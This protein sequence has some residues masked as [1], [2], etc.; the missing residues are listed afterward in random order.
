MPVVMARQRQHAV[1]AMIE[2]SMAEGLGPPDVEPNTEE[3]V[4]DFAARLTERYMRLLDHEGAFDE[5][6]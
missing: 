3:Q 5:D 2:K 4:T 1:R 6:D